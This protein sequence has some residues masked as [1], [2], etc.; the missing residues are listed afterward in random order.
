[1]LSLLPNER[2]GDHRDKRSQARPVVHISAYSIVHFTHLKL[3]PPKCLTFFFPPVSFSLFLSF[4][5]S[6]CTFPLSQP[7]PLLSNN[8][9]PHFHSWRA[10]F[11]LESLTHTL[12]KSLLRYWTQSHYTIP[13]YFSNVLKASIH[14]SFRSCRGVFNLHR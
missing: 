14:S 8:N 2:T 7:G 11:S 12:T 10:L 4:S 6:Y 3:F 9:K 1:M 5:F 13:H